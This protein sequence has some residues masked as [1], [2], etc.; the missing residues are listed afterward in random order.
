MRHQRQ[1]RMCWLR[2]E[3][4]PAYFP[5]GYT[6]ENYNKSEE[7]RRAFYRL[8]E[9]KDGTKEQ[10]DASMRSA[11]ETY[12][13][14]IPEKDIFFV[15]YGGEL[16]GTITAIY[17]PKENA[18]YVHM[19]ALREDFR[20]KHLARPLNYIAMKKIYEDGGSYA[21]LT[22]NDW[23]ENAIRGYIHAGFVPQMNA[24]L[25]REKKK[26]IDRWRKIYEKL[27]LGELVIL[28]RKKRKPIS[29]DRN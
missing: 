19:V 13:D 26:I 3:P 8:W 20:G 12:R 18:G 27:D 9:G 14:C 23:R 5:E 25:P 24:I 1:I 7:H 4:V 15:R 6:V 22:T 11:F 10:V 21:Y 28:S 29:L 2:K 17:H 16:I